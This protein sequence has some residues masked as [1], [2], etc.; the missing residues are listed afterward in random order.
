MTDDRRPRSVGELLLQAVERFDDRP[1]MRYRTES[2]WV[3][4]DW[5]DYAKRVRRI[6]AALVGHQRPS[7]WPKASWCSSV[8]VGGSVRMRQRSPYACVPVAA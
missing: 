7:S 1:A 6:S 4:I 3:D 8:S 5:R 2:E